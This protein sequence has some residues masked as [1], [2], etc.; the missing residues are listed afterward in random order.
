MVLSSAVCVGACACASGTLQDLANM[1]RDV[2]MLRGS[3]HV[4]CDPV[5]AAVAAAEEEEE[6]GSVCILRHHHV[7]LPRAWNDF[8]GTA[9]QDSLLVLPLHAHRD[10]CGM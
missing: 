9:A 8:G 1:R 5:D 2:Q 10:L 3:S 6:G 4:V 7:T